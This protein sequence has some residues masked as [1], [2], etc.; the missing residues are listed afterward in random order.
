MDDRV[1]EM[2]FGKSLKDRGLDSFPREVQMKGKKNHQLKLDT[3]LRNH[4]IMHVFLG[5]TIV[6]FDEFWSPTSAVGQTVEAIDIW[7]FM[8][9]IP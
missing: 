8:K 9:I 6:S 5:E 7:L 1:H 4:L 2:L 3:G